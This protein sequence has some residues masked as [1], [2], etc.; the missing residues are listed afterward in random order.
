MTRMTT[1]KL[2]EFKPVSVK[3]RF[4][5][6][7][8]ALPV[9]FMYSDLEIIIEGIIDRW[10]QGDRDPGSPEADYF[11]V[12]SDEGEQIMLKHEIKSNRWFFAR[13]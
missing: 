7:D 9:S 5:R 10:Y 3:L 2:P 13:L 11:K 1:A 4:D 8:E 12:V 6:N